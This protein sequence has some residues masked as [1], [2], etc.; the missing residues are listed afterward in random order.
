LI[1]FALPLFIGLFKILSY[2]LLS[3]NCRWFTFLIPLTRALL[4]FLSH[5]IMDKHTDANY[6]LHPRVFQGIEST[7]K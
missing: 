1:F 5:R 6:R 2:T 3:L 4:V 7:G